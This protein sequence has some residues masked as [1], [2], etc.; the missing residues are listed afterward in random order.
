MVTK[1]IVDIIPFNSTVVLPGENVAAALCPR[2]EIP[3]GN[4]EHMKA[5]P[6]EDGS[7]PFIYCTSIVA[8]LAYN[9]TSNYMR[10][11][12]TKFMRKQDQDCTVRCTL[13]F[14]NCILNVSTNLSA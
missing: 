7:Y 8:F 5:M 10:K 6:P 11:S 13:H 14:K 4:K 1:F 2:L 9:P 3:S 12:F